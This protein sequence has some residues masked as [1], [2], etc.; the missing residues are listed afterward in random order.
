[1]LLLTI[2]IVFCIFIF[3]YFCNFVFLYFC[4]FVLQCCE[5][6][7]VQQRKECCCLQYTLS[8]LLAWHCLEKHTLLPIVL[9]IVLDFC[10]AVFLY[11][12]ALLRLKNILSC[13]LCCQ[14]YLIAHCQFFDHCFLFLLSHVNYVAWSI[15]CHHS[16]LHDL[17]SS[18]FYVGYVF[19]P[20][21]GL[22]LQP[23]W[24][25]TNVSSGRCS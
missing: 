22:N 23:T 4:I 8:P 12:N 15:L 24:S 19:L 10:I 21:M 16:V 20:C 13:R 18:V 2:H 3:L 7:P 11:C 9:S 6:G 5:C 17:S 14:L 25:M 1:M